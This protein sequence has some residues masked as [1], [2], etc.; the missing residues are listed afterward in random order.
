VTV[1]AN[2]K[3]LDLDHERVNVDGGAVAIGHPIG[4]S[5][6]RIL[7]HLVNVLK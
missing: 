5:G 6:G 2:M 1:L 3:L 4:S 7:G